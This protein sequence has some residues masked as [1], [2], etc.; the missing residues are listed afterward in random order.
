MA[1]LVARNTLF[2]SFAIWE[3]ASDALDVATSAIASTPSFSSHFRAMEAAMS[4]LFW[5]SAETTSTFT[6]GLA[7]MKSSAAIFAASSD[8][9]PEKSE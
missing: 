6:S 3:T 8:P 1:A 9:A 2:L 7:A 4:G 5:W